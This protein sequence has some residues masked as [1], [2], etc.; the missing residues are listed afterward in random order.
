M[1]AQLEIGLLMKRLG[2]AIGAHLILLEESE[3][4]S[5][6]TATATERGLLGGAPI[7][8]RDVLVKLRARSEPSWLVELQRSEC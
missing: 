8:R 4:K 3:L 5:E 6:D 7:L 1:D 2:E